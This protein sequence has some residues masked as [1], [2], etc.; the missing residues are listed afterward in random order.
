MANFTPSQEKAIDTRDKTLLVSAA[1][2][3]GKTYT[4]TKRIICSITG[5][6]ANDDGETTS[7]EEGLPKVDIDSM[8]IVTFT[9]AAA[10]ELRQRISEAL[11]DALAKEPDN[12]RLQEQLIK[13]SGAKIS[14]IDSFYL[15]ILRSN[16]DKAKVS[17]SFRTADGS[18]LDILAKSLIEDTI[19]EFYEKHPVEFSKLAECFV[20]VK[21]GANLSNIFL[22]LYS[23]TESL[24]DGIDFLKKSAEIT[25]EDAKCD[26]LEGHYGKMIVSEVEEA[27]K[28]YLKAYED[29]SGAADLPFFIYD[30]TFAKRLLELVEQKNYANCYAHIKTFNAPKKEDKRKLEPL[31]SNHDLFANL[32]DNFKKKIDSLSE[33]FFGISPDKITE[34]LNATADIT[35]WLYDIL[36]SFEEA[37]S[38]EKKLK[39]VMSFS[40]I[41]RK[42]Y[43]L[44]VKDVIKKEENGVVGYEV[45]P[46]SI[47]IE[48]AE[49]FSQIYIDEYQ[50]VDLMQ[51]Q[52]FCAIS[53]PQARF[54]VGDIKQSIYGFRG[55]EPD[56]FANYKKTFPDIDSKATAHSDS[57]SIFMSNN[58]RCDNTVIDFANKVCSTF[59]KECAESIDYS[60]ADDLICSKD[61]KE[62]IEEKLKEING[63][64]QKEKKSKRVT[65]AVAPAELTVILPNEGEKIKNGQDEE[66]EEKAKQ[67]EAK[68]IAKRIREFLDSTKNEKEA[69]KIRPEHI[70]VLY[71]AKNMGEYLTKELAALGIDSSSDADTDYFENPDV[72]LAL[73]LLNAID[74]PQRDI[75]LAGLLRSPLFEFTLDE[76]IK[77]RKSQNSSHSLYDALKL[78]SV[79]ESD[80]AKKCKGFNDVLTSFRN[81]AAAMPVDKLIKY[82]YSSD[83][84]ISAGLSSLD[85]SNSN[86]VRLYEYARQFEASSF[87]GLYNFISYIN[88]MIEEKKKLPAESDVSCEGKVSLLSIHHSKGLEFPI[89]FV[90][91]TGAAFY[92]PESRE[93]LVYDSHFGTAMKISDSTGLARINTPMRKILIESMRK[94]QVEEEM[95][96]LYVALTRARERLIVTGSVR[97][98][99]ETLMKK[100]AINRS[101]KCKYSV[102]SASSYLDWILTAIDEKVEY[103]FCKVS[104]I[105]KNDVTKNDENIDEEVNVELEGDTTELYELLKS[106]FSFVYPHKAA[107]T[108]P[109]KISVSSLLE[110]RKGKEDNDTT[111]RYEEKYG[112]KYFAPDILS[113]GKTKGATAAER[114]TATHL[115]LQFCDFKRLAEYGVEEE[116]SR[117]VS[118][119][120]LP[121]NS[122]KLVFKR[123]LEAFSKSKLFDKIINAKNIYREQRFNIMLPTSMLDNSPEFIEQTE[124]E[125]L[126]VQGVIDLVIEDE[127]GDI[128]LFDYKTDR[129]S[130]EELDDSNALQKKMIERHGK[131]ISYYAEAIKRLFNKEC[132]G[133]FIYSTHKTSLIE[134]P[135]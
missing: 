17:P 49:K 43:N 34:A 109:A 25:R 68:Y 122:E 16:F 38:R 15:D 82:I 93:S 118:E 104:F 120:Y 125:F 75:Y 69:A 98:K 115:F 95:R 63:E 56:V 124:D 53:K 132:R 46:T 45:V 100:A 47:A 70:A 72:L 117:L 20:N 37:F 65:T 105:E 51:D 110:D 97:C 21:D 27:V 2:G 44:L 18:E 41:K 130:K 108:L 64:N 89:C 22:D 129:L 102:L 31:I 23:K 77:I 90:S 1:A 48:Y 61:I 94:R 36:K 86:L 8:L 73:C 88:K 55:A 14:T 30:V 83:I 54:M 80:L 123:E 57:A 112:S 134:M 32:R 135:I 111:D 60:S 101:F 12:K 5:K 40:D 52:I 113:S 42:V 74:N 133:A 127:N 81:N 119:K 35:E 7:I 96:L 28:F 114:G 121:T 19:D 24:P 13:M 39:N 103:P 62:E 66:E 87:K 99:Y 50:D 29:F 106:R 91:C 71:R 76:L 6:K 4:L 116:I 33:D 9:R 92:R 85:S 67:V 10:S 58:F 11:S 107:T 128:Y 78:Y 59:F 126:A 131:Q 3:S 79:G 26:L 84:F